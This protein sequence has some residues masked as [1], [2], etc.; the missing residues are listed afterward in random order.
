MY[1]ICICIVFTSTIS[2]LQQ[3]SQWMNSR[4]R[5]AVRIYSLKLNRGKKWQY[6][7]W[8]TGPGLSVS[9][10]RVNKTD[11][12]KND[13][14]S[15]KVCHPL[16]F[17]SAASQLIVESSRRLPGGERPGQCSGQHTHSLPTRQ[18]TGGRLD[19]GWKGRK[20][21][22]QEQGWRSSIRWSGQREVSE[23]WAESAGCVRW[24]CWRGGADGWH[25]VYSQY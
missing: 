18:I 9:Y 19:D 1:C 21:Y 20:Q 25:N 11:T 7:S 13:F 10:V 23:G 24:Q 3:L 16:S 22:V 14:K 2:F 15:Y 12:G 5:A 8:Q 4:T 17:F 6:L